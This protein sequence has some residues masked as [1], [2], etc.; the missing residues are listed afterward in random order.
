MQTKDVKAELF[1]IAGGAGSLKPG[2]PAY[3]TGSLTDMVWLA[4]KDEEELWR[5]SLEASNGLKLT[6]SGIRRLFESWAASPT[7]VR[8]SVA[9]R[10][11]VGE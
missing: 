4:M 8:Q 2:S 7:D 1:R 11:S 10:A 3:R 5:Y 6:C 9:P